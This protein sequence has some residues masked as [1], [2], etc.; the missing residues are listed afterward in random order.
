M[1]GSTQ[2]CHYVDGDEGREF[3]GEV[4]F[5]STL[6]FS[7]NSLQHHLVKFLNFWHIHLWKA[8]DYVAADRVDIFGLKVFNIVNE[9][10]DGF[11]RGEKRCY[12]V[13]DAE[14]GE[15]NSKDFITDVYKS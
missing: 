4:T 11:T 12:W 7:S 2:S 6:G 1:L 14:I 8:L 10:L 15:L 9:A 3:Q 13:V 5:L